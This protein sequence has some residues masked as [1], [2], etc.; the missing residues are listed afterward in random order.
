M[1][2]VYVVT[3]P[4]ELEVC[5]SVESASY[6]IRRIVRQRMRKGQR[7]GSLRSTLR[8]ALRNR[9]T[10]SILMCWNAVYKT[11]PIE[12][13]SRFVRNTVPKER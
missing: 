9:D 12:L 6:V 7:G 1:K 4:N 2:L 10:T 13:V 11:D 8:E 5:G 3:A